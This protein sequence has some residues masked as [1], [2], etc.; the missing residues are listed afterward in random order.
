MNTS[1]AQDYQELVA[2]NPK[3]RIRD[4]AALLG[5]SEA[6]LLQ[7]QDQ[8]TRL[9]P[10]IPGLLTRMPEL[11]KTMVLT[12]NAHCVHEKTGV[13]QPVQ[14][15]RHA[16][17]ALGDI[18]LRMFLGRWKHALAQS[19]QVRGRTLHSI[20]FFDAHGDAVCKV[21][22]KDP[23][24]TSYFALRDAFAAPELPPIV[25]EPKPEPEP[26]PETEV[27]VAR[28][29]SDWAKLKDTHAFFGLLRRHKVARLRA[30]ALCPDFAV[31][32]QVDMTEFLKAA[33][34]QAL[35]IMVFVGNPGN[36]QIHT[37]P[38]SKITPMGKWVNVMDPEFNLHLDAEGV[39]EI[40][41]VRKPTSDGD[42]NSLE[43][44]AADGS[45]VA[46]FFGERKEG[47]QERAAWR[48]LL[49]RFAPCSW[50]P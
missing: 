3:L 25:A 31:R 22:A 50:S 16:S 43:L 28:L 12:R 13:W 39:A 1:L 23:D 38:V 44:Y 40:W 21:Y 27:D 36:I 2:Q 18:D 32:A 15:G 42:V 29:Q 6:E 34:E 47:R 46:M 7:T 37:G 8:V 4:A 30:F 9:N 41:R 11:G 45:S 14:I 17:L 48:A 10:D 19:R 20:Q 33:A 49:D 5:S 26:E 24:L 35:P